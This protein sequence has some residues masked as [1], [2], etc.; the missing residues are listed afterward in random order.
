ML[1]P[2]LDQPEEYT[3]YCVGCGVELVRR[4]RESTGAFLERSA[5]GLRCAQTLVAPDIKGPSPVKVYEWPYTEKYPVPR[6][7]EDDEAKA[8][9]VQSLIDRRAA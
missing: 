7:D 4:P 8:D 2:P 3:R 9:Y 6:S 5:C 1:P